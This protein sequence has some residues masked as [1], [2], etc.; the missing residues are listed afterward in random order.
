MLGTLQAE[1]LGRAAEED[2]AARHHKFQVARGSV[3][4]EP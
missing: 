3:W 4:A 2:A 1:G